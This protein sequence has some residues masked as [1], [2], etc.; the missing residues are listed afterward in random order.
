MKLLSSHDVDC[1]PCASL[2][3]PRPV[4][5]NNAARSP[6]GCRRYRPAGARCLAQPL[7]RVF[8]L[9][10]CF[11]VAKESFSNLH[12]DVHVE[13]AP[14]CEELPS[15]WSINSGGSCRAS[16][17]LVLPLVLPSLCA[18]CLPLG[19]SAFD[20]TIPRLSAPYELEMDQPEIPSLPRTRHTAVS[21]DS[22][23][24][25]QPTAGCLFQRVA[26]DDIALERADGLQI[27]NQEWHSNCQRPRVAVKSN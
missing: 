21:V 17:P 27:S 9:F 11:S 3:S 10:F 14:I 22:R 1:I 24:K 8:G 2:S 20:G 6:A 26:Y 5:T 4:H 18:P 7:R 13:L 25:D 23:P 15:R 19:N 12:W 16:L